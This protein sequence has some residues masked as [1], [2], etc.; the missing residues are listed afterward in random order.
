[1]FSDFGAMD[2]EKWNYT[3]RM[4][5]TRLAPG[6]SA[7]IVSTCK[8]IAKV[9]ITVSFFKPSGET[10]ETRSQVESVPAGKRRAFFIHRDELSPK[11]MTA[12]IDAITIELR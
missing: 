1:M 10:L 8:D 4:P 3:G 7:R 11:G 9:R 2:S 6:L 12:R 5:S